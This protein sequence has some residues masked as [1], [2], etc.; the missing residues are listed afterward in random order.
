MLHGLIFTHCA[1]L[2]HPLLKDKVPSNSLFSDEIKEIH[3]LLL[4]YS[5]G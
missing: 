2:F 4:L 5:F 3:F 1:S